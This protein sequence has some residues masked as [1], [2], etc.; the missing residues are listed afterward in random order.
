MSGLDKSGSASRGGWHH[1]EEAR[2]KMS[3]AKKG[4]KVKFRRSVTLES[5]RR[6]SE[7]QKQKWRDPEHRERVTRA[8]QEGMK[9]RTG[10]L[11]V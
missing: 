3:Q 6:M 8:I 9:K 10:E 5:R 11:K 2:Q 1:S 7:A 4:R